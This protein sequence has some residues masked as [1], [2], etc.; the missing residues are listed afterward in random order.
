M[1]AWIYDSDATKIRI[2]KAFIVVRNAKEQEAQQIRE[3]RKFS[4]HKAF[5]FEDLV[6]LNA[7]KSSDLQI[8][9]G[10][11]DKKS[12]VHFIKIQGI[13]D[14]SHW[15]ISDW[16]GILLQM[17]AHANRLKFYHMNSD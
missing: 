5:T 6:Y 12:W 4:N 11:F 7:E 13:L 9:S 8:N 17:K 2:I 1:K 15:L 3:L 16:Q 14:D 10:K